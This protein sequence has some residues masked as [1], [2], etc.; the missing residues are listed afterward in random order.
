MKHPLVRDILERPGWNLRTAKGFE[1][2]DPVETKESD[3]PK[4]ESFVPGFC[5][6]DKTWSLV[7]TF[8]G[9]QVS[10]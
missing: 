4:D 3:K 5:A 9:S 8:P 2:I 10:C 7:A 6:K 1:Y